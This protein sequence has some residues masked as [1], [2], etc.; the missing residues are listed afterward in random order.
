MSQ[1]VTLTTDIFIVGSGAAGMSAAVSASASGASVIVADDREVPGGVLRQCVHSGFG[2]GRYGREM[3]G[4]EYSEEEFRHFE[5]SSA[6]YFPKCR[7][8]SIGSD[9]TALVSSPDGLRRISFIECILASGC[10]E[11]PLWSLPVAGTRPEGVYTAGEIQEMI[12]IGGYDTG[13]RIFILGSGDIGQI[14]ARRF[15]QLGK[16]VIGMAEQKAEPGGMK[17]NQEECIKAYDIP[18]ILNSTVTEVH[19]FPHLTGVTLRHLDSGTEELIECDTLITALG[20]EPDKSLAEGLKTSD[21]YPEW[22]HF[23]GNA[24][25]VHEIADSASAQGEKLGRSTAEHILV[26]RKEV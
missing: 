22:L 19:G 16:T 9:R 6:V 1:A 24:D 15:V 23:C 13:D 3:T 8:I 21:G 12:E 5:Q 7:V 25:F 14:M 20:L 2:L 10:I 18:V 4:P 26:S 17:R 11:R